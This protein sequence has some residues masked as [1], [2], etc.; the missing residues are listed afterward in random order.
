MTAVDTARQAPHDSE[1]E[2]EG[3]RNRFLYLLVF[4]VGT[5][6]LGAEIS[7]AR[8][9][10]PFF[11]ASTIVWANTI[12]V[13]LVAL[14]VGYWLGGRLGDRYP[15]LRELCLMVAAAAILLAVVPFAGRPFFEISIDALDEISAGAFVG[16]LVGVLFLIAMP[17][18]LLGT[19]SPWA[20]RLAVPDVEHSGRTAG[21]L[22]AVSTVGSLFGTMLAALVGI[23]L[24]GTQR[25]FLAFALALGLVAA[26]GLGWRF[27]VLPV[28]LAG[29]IAIPIGTVK[30]TDGEKVL[31]EGESEEQ[32][33]RVVEEEDGERQLEL[34]EG[35][36]VHSLYRPGSYLT[37]GVWDGYLVLPFA[38]R[39]EPPERMAILGN[40]AGTTARA[41]GHYFP[42]TEIDGVEIDA[43]LTGLGE[44]FFDL[45]NPKLEVF[46]EDARPWLEDSEGGYDVI[47]VDA[48]RQPYIPFYL[49]TREF[50]ELVRDR[51]APGGAV[52]VNAGH[53]EG[54]DDLEKVLGATLAEVF[55]TVL[56]DPIE[57]TNTLLLA[58]EAP[59]SADRLA[60]AVP[61]LPEDLRVIAARE[62][63]LIEPRLSGGEVYTDDRAPVEWLIDRSI[64][65]YAAED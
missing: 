43:E 3:V 60:E 56:R 11:G 6:S 26:A 57:D 44:R 50:F 42:Q 1:L 59:A 31:F 34:N 51:L 23:P 20:I 8:L 7:A 62:S 29:V 52:I 49:A 2:V 37:D 54:N 12:G 14:S 36:A 48:Y 17:V 24:I 32:Y 61:E 10:A 45:H 38:A 47:M 33:I 9:M 63:Q 64:L 5:A 15:H 65:G 39:H 30:A 41:Y 46:H 40:A 25:T 22:Y 28:A 53:P 4:V 13:V 35:Q 18:V 58:T 19:C 21:R 27:L 55:P 16:S